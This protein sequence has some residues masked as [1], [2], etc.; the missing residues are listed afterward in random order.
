[1]LRQ[2]P[3]FALIVVLLAAACS[4]ANNR[5]ASGDADSERCALRPQDSTFMAAGT[6]YRD[7]AVKS[8]AVLLTTSIHPEFYPSTQGTRGDGCYSA[9]LEFVVDAKGMVETKTARVVRTN[10]Q[11]LAEA[12]LSILPQWRFQP[13]RLNDEPVRQ[14]MSHRRVVK[15]MVAVVPLGTSPSIPAGSRHGTP[16][17]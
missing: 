15:T 14:I 9:D 5:V 10:S 12:V 1:M 7:C 8:K 16:G 3:G 4:S 17:C 6:V 11:A 13:A 2:L